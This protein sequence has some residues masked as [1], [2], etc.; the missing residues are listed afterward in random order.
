MEVVSVA[1][2]TENGTGRKVWLKPDDVTG[3]C[4]DSMPDIA[5]GRGWKVP[6]LPLNDEIEQRGKF[7]ASRRLG[8][9]SR[10]T[11]R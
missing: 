1:V 4:R 3:M 8:G 10:F 11:I 9:R 6:R 5:T 2:E 7:P